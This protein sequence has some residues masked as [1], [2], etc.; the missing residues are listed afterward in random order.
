MVAVERD[1]DTHHDGGKSG[2]LTSNPQDIDAV[3]KRAWQAIHNGMEGCIETAVQ[4]FLCSYARYIKCTQ[5]TKLHELVDR[6]LHG[7]PAQGKW[8]YRKIETC[9]EMAASVPPGRRMAHARLDDVRGL[10]H[11]EVNQ[12]ASAAQ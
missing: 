11:H 10:R 3:V 9:S 7:A 12:A 4:T 1:R 5:K 2:E 6:L 8:P